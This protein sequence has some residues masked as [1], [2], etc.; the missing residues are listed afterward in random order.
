MALI[1]LKI[2]KT[3][4]YT[5]SKVISNDDLAQIMDTNDE[6]ISS[7]TGI[8]RRHVV[9]DEDTTD[10]VVN[11]AEDLL[12]QSQVDPEDINFIVVATASASEAVPTAAACVQKAIGAKNAFV[13]DL[14]AACSGFIY[15]LSVVRGLFANPNYN[16][17]IL[18]GAEVLSKYTDWE[19][20]TTAVLFGDGAGGVLLEKNAEPGEMF[21]G[22]DLLSMGDL[23]DKI[24]M[25]GTQNNSPFSAGAT[26]DNPGKYVTMD[27]RAVYT[28]AT[29]N[30]PKSINRALEQANLTA[31]DVDLF[32]LH[33]ANARIVE[34][35][36]KKLH[37]P[38]E[39]FPMNISEYGNTSAASVPILLDE[40]NAAGKIK[41]GSVIALAGFGGGL[42]LGS[43]IIRF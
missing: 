37:Q 7:R 19:D 2:T 18:I 24:T 32:V 9:T 23:G 14:N 4:H 3:A 31:D 28:F 5:P 6:W 33:Q 1:L 20:R 25:A 17:G 22:E 36:A 38:I 40:L 21:L 35:I 8:K 15:G 42:T 13:F 11:V 27:G 29:R 41:P 12:K 16:K 10:L 34:V 30:V 26:K 43:E 39:K